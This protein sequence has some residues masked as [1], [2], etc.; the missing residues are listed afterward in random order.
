VR[1]GDTV[2][3]IPSGETWIVA[4]AD[5]RQVIACG[6]PETFARPAECELIKACSDTEHFDL[7]CEIALSPTN[8]CRR[9]RCFAEMDRRYQET[10]DQM[11]RW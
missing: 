4:W 11:M 9:R 7:M 1:T 5:E 6:Y 8:S 3:H 10:C 2:K